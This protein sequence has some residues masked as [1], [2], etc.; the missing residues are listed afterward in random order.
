MTRISGPPETHNRHRVPVAKQVLEVIRI[1][2]IVIFVLDAR[3]PGATRQPLLEQEVLTQ[4]REIVHVLN[5]ADLV[6]LRTYDPALLEGLHNPIFMSYTKKIGLGK[7]M[8]KLKILAK[9]AK[10][11]NNFERIHVGIIGYPNVGKSSLVNFLAH[12]HV[13]TASHERGLTKGMQKVRI[14]P[15]LLLLDTPGILQASESNPDDVTTKVRHLMV[16]A[17]SWDRCRDPD[18]VVHRLY[19]KHREAFERFYACTTEEGDAEVLFVQLG[20]RWNMVK[21]KGKI[22][23]IRVAR[24]MLRDWQ[25]GKIKV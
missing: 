24:Q 4:G 2:D 11:V 22:D 15:G 3:N 23:E 9:K 20:Q 8:T 10:K 5:K 6:D 18:M 13:A 16:G 1:S 12:R 19:Q 21:Q 25:E 17:E 14:G 7:L